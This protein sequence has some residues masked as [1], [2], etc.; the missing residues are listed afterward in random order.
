MKKIMIILSVCFM[1][2]SS[3]YAQTY[4]SF[5]PNYA[6]LDSFAIFT[7]GTIKHILNYEEVNLLTSLKELGS[8]EING[9]KISYAS[10]NLT[11]TSNKKK[12]TFTL[13]YDFFTS[14]E[15]A[16]GQVES[17]KKITGRRMKGISFKNYYAYQ[18]NTLSQI[19]SKYAYSLVVFR[20][21]DALIGIDYLALKEI[22][23][24]KAQKDFF[25][26]KL[27]EAN[28]STST[29]A[30]GPYTYDMY[31]FGSLLSA[32]KTKV[33]ILKYVNE[34]GTNAVGITGEVM[35]RDGKTFNKILTST[36][37]I[38]NPDYLIWQLTH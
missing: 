8:L 11:I 18:M 32:V 15:K 37:M 3:T 31:A 29:V 2:L 20:E 21:G 38:E 13:S 17:L 24:S 28:T 27:K 10:N 30:F 26:K 23:I 4:Q 25:V 35:E 16:V 33:Y 6:S 14:L 34:K 1:A 7:Q 12:S 5:K 19:T 9:K 36:I 22:Y